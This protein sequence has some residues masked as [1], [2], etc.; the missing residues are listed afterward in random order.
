MSY[1]HKGAK[2]QNGIRVDCYPLMCT[3]FAY[4]EVRKV[5]FK[6]KIDKI[7]YIEEIVQGDPGSQNM[8]KALQ[9]YAS[10]GPGGEETFRELFPATGSGPEKDSSYQIDA[11]KLSRFLGTLRAGSSQEVIQSIIG[12]IQKVTY[13]GKACLS[14]RQ[15]QEVFL[16]GILFAYVQRK[17]QMGDLQLLQEFLGLDGT[18]V[19]QEL[20]QSQPDTEIQELGIWQPTLEL[21]CFAGRTGKDPLRLEL[22]VLHNQQDQPAV[23]TL[24]DC[25]LRRHLKPKED[26]LVLKANGQVVAFLPRVC[27]SGDWTVYQKERELVAEKGGA[28][29]TIPLEGEGCVFFSESERYGFMIADRTGAFQGAQFKGKRPEGKI[30][31]Q[32]GDL[33]NYGFLFSDGSYQGGLTFDTRWKSLLFFDLSGGHGVAVTADRSAINERGELL[34]KQIA[35]VSCC[36]EHYILLRMDGTVVTDRGPVEDVAGPARAVCADAQGYWISTDQNLLY[37]NDG[38][39]TYPQP[40]EEIERNNSGSRVGGL[41]SEN[42]LWVFPGIGGSI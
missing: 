21:P 20:L 7:G 23:V 39:T 22:A 2:D 8:S 31:W 9:I 34:G 28:T 27:M 3:Y 13:E 24:Q 29:Q 12:C 11:D 42:Q 19:V 33:Q 26:L 15:I 38:I 41:S 5:I 37:W 4:E 25:P 17:P 6:E 35:A 36:G 32:K 14:L 30:C 10:G 40:L 1:Q 18:Q 16:F